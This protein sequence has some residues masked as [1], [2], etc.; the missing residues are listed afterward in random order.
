VALYTDWKHVY[1]RAAPEAEQAA[2]AVPVTQFGRMC[3]ALQIQIIPANSPQAKGRVERNHGT[4]QD[5][6]IKK[7]LRVQIADDTA[8]NHYLTTSYWAAHNGR[9]ALA[10]AAA[11]DLH[12]RA[13]S[14]RALDQIFRLEDTRTI[15][16]DWGARY[17][18]RHFQLARQSGHAPARSHVRVCEWPDGRLAIEY[19]GR[20][21][22]WTEIEAPSAPSPLT[23]PAPGARPSVV[24]PASADH[25][26]RRGYK[27]L[28]DRCR[29]SI[30]LEDLKG[31]FLTSFDTHPPP[32]CNDRGSRLHCAQACGGEVFACVIAQLL[33]GRVG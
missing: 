21:M 10:A 27:G 20:P 4:H 19:R 13:P 23:R 18:N 1:V 8:A 32:V 29:R 6:L 11:T 26:W 5:R 24:R 17:H 33:I 31:I 12:R 30:G 14:A 28:P 7:L 2:G 25:P 15:G 9:F 22:T 16:L 3:A